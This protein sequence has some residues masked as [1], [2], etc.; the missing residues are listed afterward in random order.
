MSGCG[1]GF[2]NLT[3][4]LDSLNPNASMWGLFIQL[5]EFLVVSLVSAVYQPKGLPLGGMLVH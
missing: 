5:E 3:S 4:A 1:N 2:N